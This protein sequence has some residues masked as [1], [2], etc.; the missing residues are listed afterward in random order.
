MEQSKKA[1]R[2]AILGSDCGVGKTLTIL[3]ALVQSIKNRIEGYKAKKLKLYEGE[4]PYK[5]SLLHCPSQITGQ[6]VKEVDRWYGDEL[7]VYVAHGSDTASGHS[8]RHQLLSNSG[9][10]KSLMTR[11]AKD[12]TLEAVSNSLF[13]GF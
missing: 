2:A 6:I 13:L 8:G 4:K 10:L 1:F 11:L 3:M 5:P 12:C 7:N 9:E